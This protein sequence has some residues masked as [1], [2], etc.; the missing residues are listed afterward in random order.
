MQNRTGAAICRGQS[1][2]RLALC[3]NAYESTK[4]T[5]QLLS[6]FNSLDAS[7]SNVPILLA[8]A[9]RE[10]GERNRPEVMSDYAEWIDRT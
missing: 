5:H 6:I 8:K 4:M 9:A 3:G 2:D 1:A 7:P 10:N